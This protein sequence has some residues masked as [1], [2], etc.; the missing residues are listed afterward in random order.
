MALSIL[1]NTGA[2]VAASLCVGVLVGASIISFMTSVKAS[3]MDKVAEDLNVTLMRSLVVMDDEDLRAGGIAPA[4][5]DTSVRGPALD[6]VDTTGLLGREVGPVGNFKARFVPCRLTKE[7]FGEIPLDTYVSTCRD[8]ARNVVS[9]MDP[10][11]V[12]SAKMT[13]SGQKMTTDGMIVFE[14]RPI[15]RMI[16]GVPMPIPGQT[17]GEFLDVKASCYAVRE[18]VGE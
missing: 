11:A 2:Q 10:G 1:R 4:P 17:V 5:I 6:S 16:G 15:C 9:P 12:R 8:A 14:G 18:L 13:L 7:I 3:D